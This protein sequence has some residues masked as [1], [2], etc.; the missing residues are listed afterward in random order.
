[1]K[2]IN[3]YFQRFYRIHE[4]YFLRVMEIYRC[5]DLRTV[6]CSDLIDLIDSDKKSHQQRHRIRNTCLLNITRFIFS[7]TGPLSLSCTCNHMRLNNN[8]KN[9]LYVI[10]V[11]YR[12]VYIIWRLHMSEKTN[13]KYNS[14]QHR[15]LRYNGIHNEYSIKSQSASQYVLIIKMNK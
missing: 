1:M 7:K 15:T 3:W 11:Y 13:G 12:T 8:E 2:N 9:I 10:C 4:C 5:Q 14:S 6:T